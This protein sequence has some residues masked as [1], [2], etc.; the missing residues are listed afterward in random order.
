MS[1]EESIRGG[2]KPLSC[3]EEEEDTSERK[4]HLKVDN[5]MSGGSLNRSNQHIDS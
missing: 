1:G 3:I 4:T 2:I 5:Y